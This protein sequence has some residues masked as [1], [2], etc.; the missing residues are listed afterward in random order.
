MAQQPVECGESGES[1]HDSNQDHKNHEIEKKIQNCCEI[2]ES[3]AAASQLFQNS[4]D[5][6][7]G[8]QQV[9][10]VHESY[11]GSVFHQIERKTQDIF[12]RSETTAAASQLFE[13]FFDLLYLCTTQPNI[14][15][16][17]GV[18]EL[19]ASSHSVTF[20][21]SSERLAALECKLIRRSSFESKLD[22]LNPP[23]PSAQ[24]RRNRKDNLLI[25]SSSFII[26]VRIKFA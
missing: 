8:N 13:N 15:F 5:I 2:A 23:P 18:G 17:S 10:C 12:E 14:T 9:E 1:S 21:D 26:I 11:Q 7:D 22:M 3:T 24:Y 16:E 20:S 19:S 6:E 25:S 4:F